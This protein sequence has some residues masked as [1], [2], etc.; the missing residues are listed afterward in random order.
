MPY[1]AWAVFFA[2]LFTGLN[3]RGIKAS[4]RTN[5]IIAGGLGV[6]L[7]LFIVAAVRYLW[8]QT[9]DGAALA[10]PFYDPATLLLVEGLERH[11]A[12]R[13]HLHRLRRHL[14]A[15]G[16]GRESAP[17]HPAG[18]GDRLPVHRRL[19]RAPG[20]PRRSSSG[21]TG[22]ATPTSTP[23]SCTWPD[24]PAGRSCSRSSTS[25]CSWRTSAPVRARS[26][27]RGGSST[28]WDATTPSPAA[29][30]ARYTRAPTSRPTTSFSWARSRSSAPSSLSYELGAELLNFGAFIAFMGV[31][32]AWLVHYYVRGRTRKLGNLVPPLLGFLI[33]LY[34]WLSLRIPTKVAGFVWLLSGVLYGAWKTQGFKK[35]IEFRE[36][37]DEEADE[38][39]RRLPEEPDRLPGHPEELRSAPGDEGSASLVWLVARWPPRFRR[40]PRTAAP[41]PV[42]ERREGRGRPDL[43]RRDGHPP[44]QRRPRPRRGRPR[45]TFFVPGHSS[46]W[47][48]A[49][50]SG[51]PSPR[52]ATSS[53]NHAIFHPC[54]R[55]PA[56]GPER[57]WVKPEYALEGYIGRAHPGRGG[58]HE[59]D[60][61]RHRR[62]EASGRSPTTAA[63]RRPAASRT[64]R[65]SGRSS[66]PPAPARTGSPPT[67][68]PSTRCSCRAGRPRT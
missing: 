62:R 14:D 56:T 38:G 58:G 64:S 23:P 67:W 45:G 53:A 27:A 59:H 16:G 8:G 66:W 54:L 36:A 55:K 34:L 60:A 63:T 20:L 29:S 6:V 15:L 1:A 50:P 65:R 19:R 32:V 5:A 21:R 44:R 37:N 31:N 47:R 52:A 11:R 3:L 33:C 2:V 17:Q 61:P 28:A 9:L 26:S 24:A 25:R 49:C 22:R 30:S 46:R 57:E 4:A 35:P 42:A 43:R 10:R 41:L 18:D 40:L 51:A 7:V 13:A 68:A 48:S 39:P 12:R